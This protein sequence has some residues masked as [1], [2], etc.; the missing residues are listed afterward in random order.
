MA[1]V[2]NTGRNGSFA[3]ALDGTITD[4]STAALNVVQDPC[5]LD[6]AKRTSRLAD[7]FHK[8]EQPGPATPAVRGIG[9]CSAVRPLKAV[10]FVAER[11]WIVPLGIVL[12]FGTLMGLGY[13]AGK[14]R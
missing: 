5:L 8:G 3:L 2:K 4:V 12:L 10:T 7:L 9:L 13:I 6:V 14:E 11:P 1:Y